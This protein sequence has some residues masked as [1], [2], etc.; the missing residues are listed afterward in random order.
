MPHC[1][2]HQQGLEDLLVPAEMCDVGGYPL[3][4]DYSMNTVLMVVVIAL[5]RTADTFL[6]FLD[7][8][9]EINCLVFPRFAILIS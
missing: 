2:P 1:K 8:N 3:E 5:N 4:L 6:I 7:I 9:I